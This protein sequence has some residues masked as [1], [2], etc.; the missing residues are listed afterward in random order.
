[1]RPILPARAGGMRPATRMLTNESLDRPAEDRHM[2]GQALPAP[3]RHPECGSHSGPR[4]YCGQARTGQVFTARDHLIRQ[5]FEVLVPL[6][7]RRTVAGLAF[8]PLLGNYFLVRFDLARP[9]WRRISGT[10]GVVQLFPT[11]EAPRPLRDAEVDLLRDLRCDHLGEPPR[12]G[13][14]LER[15]APVRCAEGPYRGA[16]GVVLDVVS[17]T[18]RALLFAAAGPLDVELPIRWCVRS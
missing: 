12:V 8:P 9:G 16:T 5:E 13:T 2:I 11:T 15:G 4:W 3:S 18:V 1:M 7:V 10:R 17:A 14:G 6:T